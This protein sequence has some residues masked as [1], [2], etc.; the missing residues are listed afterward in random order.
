MHALT[1]PPQLLKEPEVAQI[2]ANDML[3]LSSC[4]F[5]HNEAS[6]GFNEANMFLIGRTT[7]RHVRVHFD[8]TQQEST[9][10]HENKL[11]KSTQQEMK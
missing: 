11:Q 5:L 6:F 3:I 1:C 7:C 9:Q 4:R 8:D 2:T 10:F